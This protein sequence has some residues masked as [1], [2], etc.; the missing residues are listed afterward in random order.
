MRTLSYF[1]ALF[2]A[3]SVVDTIGGADLSKIDRSIR[4]EP[5]YR[6][7]PMYC[8]LVFGP[9]AK[10]RVWLVRDGNVLYVDRNGN[11]DLTESGERCPVTPDERL[12]TGWHKCAAGDIVETDGKTVQRSLY[13]H[14]YSANEIALKLKAA[15]GRE[16][17]LW[18]DVGGGI[19]LSSRPQDA[20][21]V[22][23]DG[24]LTFGRS[25]YA[26]GVVEPPAGSS[27]CQALRRGDKATRLSFQLGTPGLGK[28]SFASINP[29]KA[30][31]NSAMRPRAEIEFP[32]KRP[33]GPPIR[34]TVTLDWDS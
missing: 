31:S 1:T 8:L 33:G 23:F 19:K 27:Y 6:G 14:F 2:L 22:H 12:S 13:V 5:T 34:T 15:S 16:Y 28:D 21:V 25:S 10:S 7:K 9:E 20:A 18:W 17:W 30:V 26:G 29:R 24:P 4:K 32:S 3:G 11:G